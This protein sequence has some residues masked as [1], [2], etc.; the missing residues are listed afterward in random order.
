MCSTE[1]INSKLADAQ[2][3]QTLGAETAKHAK[4]ALAATVS[5]QGQAIATKAVTNAQIALNTVMAVGKQLLMSFAVGAAIAGIQALISLVDKIHVSLEEANEKLEQSSTEFDNVTSSIESMNSQLDELNSQIKEIQNSGELSLTDE[6][7]LA[8]LKEEKEILEMQLELEKMKAEEARK[9]V[10]EDTATAVNKY[11][12]ENNSIGVSIEDVAQYKDQAIGFYFGSN[13]LPKML[14]E[15]QKL[16]ELR[17]NAFGNPELYNQYNSQL[18]EV[19]SSILDIARPA[20]G[21]QE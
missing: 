7:D 14:A 20:Y 13:E 17:D 8:N 10:A 9:Q 4:E 2:V 16:I 18:S 1:V 3:T 15:Y 5:M 19:K 12:N 21:L 11:D 6:E